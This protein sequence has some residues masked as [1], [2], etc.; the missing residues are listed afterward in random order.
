MALRVVPQMVSLVVETRMVPAWRW[1]K[2]FLSLNAF[3]PC[4]AS[5]SHIL[6]ALKK[7]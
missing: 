6:R 4:M 7:K 2:N 5:V 1:T 3:D